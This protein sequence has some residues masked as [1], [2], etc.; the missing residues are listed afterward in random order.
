LSV[1]AHLEEMV[2]TGIARTDGAAT[3]NSTYFAG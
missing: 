1:F 3:L 2:A